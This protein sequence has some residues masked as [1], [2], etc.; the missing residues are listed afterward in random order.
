MSKLESL[1]RQI[2]I[3]NF[4]L[5]RNADFEGIT[6]HLIEKEAFDDRS[7]VVSKRTFER[8]LQEIS[9]LFGYEISYN[10]SLKKY[11][12][13]NTEIDNASQRIIEAFDL[14]NALNHSNSVS[15]H[16]YFEQRKPQGTEHM[17]ILLSAISKKKLVDFKYQKFWDDEISERVV[18][19][20]ALREFKNRWYLVAKDQKDNTIKTFGLDRMTNP[21]QKSKKFTFP[22][23]SVLKNKFNHCFGVITPDEGEPETIE[24]SFTPFQAKYIKTM[25]LHHSQEIIEDNETHCLIKLKL[26]NTIDLRMEIL[27]YGKEVKVIKP[28]TLANQI[29]KMHEEAAKVKG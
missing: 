3:I 5:K 6:Q 7:Y 21:A 20:Y 8:D 28:K 1:S 14:L 16:I 25:P 17:K 27:S 26:F 11:R 2:Y 24:L 19:P 12:I 10:R 15:Q 18:E 22:D 29:K 13:E 9:S 23:L 4:L